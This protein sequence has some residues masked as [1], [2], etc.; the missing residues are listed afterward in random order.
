MNKSE[1]ITKVARDTYLTKDVVERVLKSIISNVISE[2]SG[3]NQVKIVDFGTFKPVKRNSRT[4]NNINTGEHVNIPE[5]Y[6]PKFYP[7]KLFKDTVN[8]KLMQEGL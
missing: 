3:G 6:L 5:R 2:V 7:G 4:G 8:D 1:L